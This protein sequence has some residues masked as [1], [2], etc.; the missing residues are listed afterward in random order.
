MPLLRSI[1]P[2]V[3]S[4]LLV[5]MPLLPGGPRAPLSAPQSLGV[6]LTVKENAF[7][8]AT[9]FPVSVVAPLPQGAYPDV[10]QLGIVGVPSQVEEL[11]RWPDGGSLR[12]VL[13]HFLASAPAGGDAIYHL[14]DGGRTLP[15]TPVTVSEANGSITITTG[16]LRLRLNTAAFN[17][18]DAVWLDQDG[19][20]QYEAGEQ[21]VAPDP[22][23]GGVFS[24]RAGAGAVQYDSA[25]ANPSIRIEERGPVR[26]VVRVEAPAR[27]RSTTD[28][29]HGFAVR[30]YAY[31]GLPFVRVEYQLQNSDETVV[32]A[33]PLYFESFTL[34]LRPALQ[35]PTT[36]RFGL[37]DGAVRSQ[38]LASGGYLAQEMHDH[39]AVYTLPGP[40][41]VLS[42]TLPAGKGPNAFIDLSDGQ[43]GVMATVR[44]FWQTWPNGL[45][46]DGQGRLR[47][48]LFPAWSAH[49]LPGSYAEPPSPSSGFSPTGLY[50]LDDM[51]HYYKEALFHFHGPGATDADLVALQRTFQF[52]PVVMVP[53]A[54]RRQTAATLD[55]DGVIPSA[56]RLPPP[57]DRRQ[58]FYYTRGFNTED[59]YDRNN[60]YYGAGWVNFWDPEPG[61][62]GIACT[63]GGIPYAGARAIASGSPADYFEAEGWGSAEVNLRPEWLT[64]YTHDADWNR[65]QLSENPYCGGHWR[66]YEPNVSAYA[67]P[68]LPGTLKETPVFYARDDAHGWFYHV[69]E[70]YWLTG[71]PWI[72]DWYE[73]V[74]EFRRARL[75]QLDPFPD[76]Y[77]RA[78][79]H[80]LAHVVQAAR[81]AGRPDLLDHFAAY[82]RNHLRP[83]QDR[84]YGD[85]L[86]D[87]PYGG[88]FQTGYLARALVAYLEEQRLA[89][90]WQAYAEGFAYL[91]GLV[92]WN[93]NF[94]NFPYY[95]NPRDGGK[96][97]SGG[98][99]LSMVDPAA[100]YYWHTGKIKYRQ[101]LEDYLDGGIDGGIPPYGNF[102]TWEGQFEGRFYLWMQ[103]AARPA[104]QPPPAIDDLV[105]VRLGNDV[106]LQWTA[107]ASA[108]RYLVVWADRPIVEE[109]SLDLAVMNWWAANVVGPDL[110]PTPGQP[111]S[112]NLATGGATPVYA[113][114]FS[115]DAIDNMSAMS[116]LAL[117][118]L[119]G[120]GT[121]TRTSTPTRTPSATP[122]ASPTPTRTLTRTP[123]ATPTASPT[124]T[125]SPTATTTPASGEIGGH[126]WLDQNG[127]G[128]RDAGEPP[129]PGVIIVLIEGEMAIDAAVTAADGG[130]R[131]T[132]LPP[133]RYRVRE[134]QPA[135][136]RLS[137]TP[138]EVEAEVLPGATVRVDF[139]D[140][141]GWPVWL[142]LLVRPD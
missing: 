30:I 2:L 47:L 38:P 26:A 111:Q 34:D 120:T 121:P 44:N 106:Q 90:D 8:G 92:E 29:L 101:Q 6:P 61:Y 108:A 118:T 53:A 69:A 42:A 10:S 103:G 51:Q 77:S 7:V 89:G 131:F 93:Y 36:L 48:E 55:L 49:W 129:V 137:T 123:S 136:L 124:R 80:S 5:V 73:F 45:A 98:E 11:E 9:N 135:G 112:L 39:H 40:T 66:I 21:I 63:G 85:N 126:T 79:A 13:V 115:F 84:R 116:N 138:D 60:V 70:S 86:S 88:G 130:Y 104:V 58:P 83:G 37:A 24:P 119:P 81:V 113:A 19:D 18:F 16:P 71:N 15:A 128:L 56:D 75:D 114:I 23:N 32:R 125:P 33:W 43:R 72:R 142:P 140:W 87:L 17:L 54:W 132:A 4:A 74:A 27:F 105:A 78:Q 3:A 141:A 14:T 65:L 50:W 122:T 76:L 107:P 133:A 1:P 52:P 110:Q 28:H 25:R 68:P 91:S 94:G 31:A 12:H 100:W 97:Q 64:G 35:G 57:D 102:S 67:A 95:F 46:A 127:D 96:G 62:R 134:Q 20:G 22:L 109:Q 139:G 82:V 117:A 99:S 41:R 59:W